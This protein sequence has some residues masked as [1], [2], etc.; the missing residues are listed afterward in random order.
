M[1]T[2]TTR[3][4][5]PFTPQQMYALVADVEHYPKF[6][7]MCEALVVKSR[8]QQGAT[9]I[10]VCE[11]RVGYMAI[12]ER[13]V[14]KVRLEPEKPFVQA[15]YLDGPFRQLDNTWQFRPAPNGGCD[16]E[17]YVAYE[18]KSMVLQLLM[19]SMFDIAFRRFAEAFEERARVVYGLPAAK[20]V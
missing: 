19:G 11:M 20:T 9:E 8:A 10:L 5:V 16:I 6:L 17:F 15:A 3:R 18:F 1:T 2:F 4:R 12:Q 14:C 13:F 7:P